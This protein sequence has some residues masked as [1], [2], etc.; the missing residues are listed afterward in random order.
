M[1]TT[2]G[3]KRVR[4][5]LVGAAVG[6]IGRAVVVAWSLAELNSATLPIVLIGAG[7]GAAIGAMAGLVGRIALGA[8]VGA[9]L[10]LIVFTVT[11]PAAVLVALMGGGSMPSVVA[12]VATGAL[13]GLAAGA[14]ARLTTPRR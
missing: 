8:I 14:A 13:S 11:L 2:M 7:I 5:V 1:T 12:A 9:G 6:G 10:A 4:G 3:Q